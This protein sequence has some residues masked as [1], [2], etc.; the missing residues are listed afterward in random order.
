MF[1]KKEE[2]TMLSGHAQVKAKSVKYLSEGRFELV[3]TDVAPDDI[4]EL[5]R[6]SG[7]F[8]N[9]QFGETLKTD[10]GYEDQPENGRLFTTNGDG[11]V[12]MADSEETAKADEEFCAD[13]AGVYICDS[14][15]LHVGELGEDGDD[16]CPECKHGTLIYHECSSE[17]TADESQDPVEPENVANETDN[18]VNDPG[19]ITDEQEIT[20]A[21]LEPIPE[22]PDLPKPQKQRGRKKSIA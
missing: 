17:D 2:K 12:E 3:L 8:V 4:M 16:A 10:R 6:C 18:F 19:D 22:P 5:L 11:V 14:C 9:F 21:D 15:G 20:L 7:K 13:P 1:N